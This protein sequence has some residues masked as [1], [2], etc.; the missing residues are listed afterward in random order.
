MCSDSSVGGWC[1]LAPILAWV[2]GVT[3]LP[4]YHPM[5]GKGLPLKAIKPGLWG[6]T[7]AYHVCNGWI[8]R[9]RLSRFERVQ[10]AYAELEGGI[11]AIQPMMLLDRRCPKYQHQLSS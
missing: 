9:G 2:G 5:E 7:L 8:F 1:N 11:P 3:S 10:S 4:L 6:L